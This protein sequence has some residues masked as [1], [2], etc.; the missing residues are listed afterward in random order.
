MATINDI[1]KQAGVSKSTVSRL[2]N[3]NGYVRP[4]TAHRI[5]EVMQG[6]NYRPDVFAKGM[7]TKRS[8]S[9]GIIFPDLSNP[10]F[11]EWYSHVESVTRQK[12]Y[13]NY[14]C[15]TDPDG[16]TEERR[17]DDLLARHIDGIIFFSYRKKEKLLNYLRQIATETP[18]IVCDSMSATEGLHCIYPDDRQGIEEATTYLIASGR[19]RIAF[20]KGPGQYQVTDNRLS[21]YME[22][23]K[24]HHIETAP[25]YIYEGDFTME[26]GRKAAS[27]FMDLPHPPDAIIAA[28]DN[29]ALGTLDYLK[30]SGI[31]VPG[32][33]AVCG[34]DD[35][36]PAMHSEP[37]LTSIKI[38]I[39]RMAHDTISALINRIEDKDKTPGHIACRCKLIIRK[40]TE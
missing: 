40:S 13:M 32:N 16:Y 22:A 38:P 27:H 33:V 37:P 35:L 4:E 17:I 23:L 18:V 26:S 12:G 10:F 5:R 20:I 7:R 19:K 30:K 34:F 15:I 9:I 24:K 28:T 8:Y 29:M 36:H 3:K 31:P 6:L 1:A 14:I 11:P 21:G 39:A 2:I 25:E